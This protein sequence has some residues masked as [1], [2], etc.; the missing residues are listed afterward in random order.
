MPPSGGMPPTSAAG[1]ATRTARRGPG[2]GVVVAGDP[3]AAAH[4]HREDR[5]GDL[6]EGDHP[7]A[8]LA[9]G[10]GDLV[11]EPDREARIVDQ[12][13]DRQVEEVAQ[14]EV[15]PELVA[16]VGG[17]RAAVHVAAVGGD[18]AHRDGR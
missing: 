3:E 5:H 9:D 10:A 13:Q 17:Q 12:V 15:A 4:D 2:R 11:L 14:V 18:H 1:H 6:G 16:A 8:A 7:L